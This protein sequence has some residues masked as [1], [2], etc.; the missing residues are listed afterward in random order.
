MLASLLR[1][2]T[3]QTKMEKKNYKQTVTE[4]INFDSSTEQKMNSV[5]TSQNSVLKFSD[6]TKY[7]L[8]Q[9]ISQQNEQLA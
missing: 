2:T 3:A 7:I 9:C 4:I 5:A 6:D 8:L 1:S